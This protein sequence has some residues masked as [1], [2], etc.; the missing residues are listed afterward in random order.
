V[1]CA[2]TKMDINNDVEEVRAHMD[3]RKFK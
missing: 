2:V 1:Y 3:G